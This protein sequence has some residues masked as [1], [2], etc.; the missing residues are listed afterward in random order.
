MKWGKSVRQ[1][2]R[3]DAHPRH[4]PSLTFPS[5]NFFPEFRSFSFTHLYTSRLQRSTL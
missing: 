4:W 5:A 3:V 2:R 1:S